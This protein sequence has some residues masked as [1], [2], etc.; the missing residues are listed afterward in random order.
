[1]NPCFGGE[2]F[3]LK[4]EQLAR[5]ETRLRRMLER[6]SSELRRLKKENARPV[7]RPSINDNLK[8][9]ELYRSLRERQS[10]PSG[11]V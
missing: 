8:R 10:E 6:A 9:A 4:L 11:T 2:E 1:M 5:Q 3:R 7:T